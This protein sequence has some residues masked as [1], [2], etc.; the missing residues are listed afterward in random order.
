MSSGVIADLRRSRRPGV[1]GQFE[2]DLLARRAV[3]GERLGCGDVGGGWARQ[4]RADR[5]DG[6][7][8]RGVGVEQREPQQLESGSVLLQQLE[9]VGEVGG[10]GVLQ[11]CGQEVRQLGG[12]QLHPGGSVALFQR[13]QCPAA[14]ARLAV[15]PPGEVQAAAAALVEHRDV[16]LG[17]R[18]G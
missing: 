7:R 10:G 5:L 6:R 15:A 3:A 11:R 4:Q 16:V 1:W 8:E 17:E 9:P 2:A 14:A 13:G 18:S 12:V